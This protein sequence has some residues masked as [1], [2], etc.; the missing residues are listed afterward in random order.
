MKTRDA[1][2]WAASRKGRGSPPARPRSA[3]AASR[4]QR[5]HLS[6][7]GSGGRGVLLLCVVA[8]GD[9]RGHAG[10]HRRTASLRHHVATELYN[11]VDSVNRDTWPF[12]RSRTRS[13]SWAASPD[14]TNRTKTVRLY[15]NSLY[16]ALECARPPARL[17]TCSTGCIQRNRS[18]LEH[19]QLNH[20]SNSNNIF[21]GRAL[22]AC[23]LFR[24][25]SG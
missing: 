3:E 11:L 23:C 21:E 7:G 25:L 5:C 16:L 2:S 6:G 10:L 8:C 22:D 4:A 24:S 15:G 17:G 19:P 20:A 9:A 13:T 1:T 18:H 14:G 12:P